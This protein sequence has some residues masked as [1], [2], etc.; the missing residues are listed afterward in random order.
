MTQRVRVVVV[1]FNGGELTLRCLRSVQ[2][3]DWPADALDVVLVDNASSSSIVTRVREEL[4]DVHIIESP[5]NLGFAGGCNLGMCDRD[6]VDYVALVNNDAW[7]EPGWLRPLVAAL[8]SSPTVGAACPKI[9]IDGRFAEVGVE[10]PTHQR[11]RGDHRDLSV[12]IS[13]ARVG[14]ID[15]WNRVQWVHGDWGREPGAGTDPEQ[16]WI[17]SAAS[18]RLPVDHVPTP[19]AELRLA[20]PEATTVAI[21]TDADSATVAVGVEPQWCS[22]PVGETVSVINNVGSRVVADG[23]G[24]DIGYLEVDAGQ[25]D[26]IR[27]VEAWCGAAVLLRADYLDDVG[28]FDERLFLYYEDLELSLRGRERG[29]TYRCVPSSVVHHAHAATSVEGSSLSEY[30]NERNRLAVAVRH[31]RPGAAAR[32]FARHVA[33]TASY[34]RRDVLS[35]LLHGR[36]PRGATAR[37]RLRS[38]GAALRLVP[39]MAGAR[40]RDRAAQ[41]SSH[42]ISP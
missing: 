24:A 21:R 14:G 30:Y 37:R 41:R 15:V 31:T 6:G 34:A 11:G 3:T 9:L 5:S 17:G 36:R 28:E 32:I 13:G 33:I 35:P 19:T 18:L 7:V 38:L 12:A 10:A 16:R 39:A 8:E 20:A 40:R 2:A 1:D 23:Y 25:Y 27:D 22:I 26:T 4:P 29:W 42:G